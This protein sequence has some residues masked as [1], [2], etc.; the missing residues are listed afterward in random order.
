M[1]GRES[2]RFNMPE[3]RLRPRYWTFGSGTVYEWFGP[4]NFLDESSGLE[5]NL[6]FGPSSSCRLLD[7]VTGSLRNSA[8]L[9][10]GNITGSWM[11][12]LLCDG[13]VLWQGPRELLSSM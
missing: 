11:G 9:E 3:L 5:C 8:G 12:P 4:V 2:V 10:I 1:K 7:A 13:E 6:S